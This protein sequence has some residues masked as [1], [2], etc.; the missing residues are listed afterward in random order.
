M[1][2]K[3]SKWDRP[4]LILYIVLY[5]IISLSMIFN[6]PFGNPP[7]EANRDKISLYIAHHHALPNGYD[8]EIRIPGYGFSYGFQPIL[9]YMIQGGVMIVSS[10]FVEGD[11]PLLYAARLTDCVF[12][13]IMALFVSS[14]RIRVFRWPSGR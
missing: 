8:E 12:G 1:K 4:V 5:L 11:R 3:T 9:P 13:L 6:Q 7:D 14:R 2:N 10:N